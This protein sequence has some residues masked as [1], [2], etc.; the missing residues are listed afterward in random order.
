[1]SLSKTNFTQHRGGED[2]QMFDGSLVLFK[3]F[4]TFRFPYLMTGLPGSLILKCSGLVIFSSLHYQASLQPWLAGKGAMG[5]YS[6]LI[7]NYY[8]RRL[9]ESIYQA[10]TSC[11]ATPT[12]K[13]VLAGLSNIYTHYVTT[14]EEYQLQRYEGAATLYGPHTL[15]AHQKQYQFLTKMLYQGMKPIHSGP[16]P[17]NQMNKVLSLDPGVILDIPLMSHHFGDCVH[18]PQP[19]AYPGQVVIAK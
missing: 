2:G 7:I 16:V 10:A 4:L 12:T 14:Y 17:P 5:V 15:L 8:F 18:Q 3:I 1:M 19:M 13:V 6:Y 9:R 11:G